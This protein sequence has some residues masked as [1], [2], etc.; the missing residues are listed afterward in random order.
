MITDANRHEL[1]TNSN[2]HEME[3]R[4]QGALSVLGQMNNKLPQLEEQ[5]T[6]THELDPNSRMLGPELHSEEYPSP[7][8]LETT[9][10]PGIAAHSPSAPSEPVSRKPISASTPEE[11]DD[12]DEEGMRILQ[13]R[14]ERIRAEK[15]RLQKIQELE[16]LEEETKRAILDKGRRRGGGASGSGGGNG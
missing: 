14:I 6:Q 2:V 3:Q 4:K 15:E 11:E 5:P 8:E 13:D 16:L 9:S 1:I 7:Y 10:R 12:D